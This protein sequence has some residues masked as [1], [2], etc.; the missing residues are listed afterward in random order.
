M[1]NIR[2]L[3]RKRLLGCTHAKYP[4][5]TTV[6]HIY[7]SIACLGPQVYGK[8][9]IMQH[10]SCNTHDHSILSLRNPILLWVMRCYELSSNSFYAAKVLE[11]A[12]DEFTTIVAPK[13]LHLLPRFFLNQC[14]N[15][16]NFE[17]VSLFF[18]MK[19]IQ[20]LREKIINKYHIV[21]VL[22]CRSY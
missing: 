19:K 13:S 5:R 11:F 18:C 17:Y 2:L 1:G 3:T 9:L 12:R 10:R 8:A 7:C 16:Q 20:H 14:L 6:L 22:C 4:V 21:P 15:S